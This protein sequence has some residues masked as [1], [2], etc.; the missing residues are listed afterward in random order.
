MSNR[1]GV[2]IPAR[3][4]REYLPEC[5]QSILGQSV[6]PDRVV[7]VD[8][9][10]NPPLQ[11]IAEQHGIEY[12]RI[13]LGDGSSGAAAR[14]A[15]AKTLTDCDFILPIDSDD[16]I[17]TDYIRKMLESFDG[18]HRL[19]ICYPTLYKFGQETAKVDDMYS[20]GGM[21][22]TD[23]LRQV[24]WFPVTTAWD[25]QALAQRIG[26]LGWG[27]GWSDAIYHYRVHG[28]S[29]STPWQNVARPYIETVDTSCNFIHALLV[30]TRD[31]NRKLD[32]DSLYWPRIESLIYDYSYIVIYPQHEGDGD[33]FASRINESF[34]DISS[35]WILLIDYSKPFDKDDFD[36]L[37]GSI[38]PKFDLLT[39]SDEDTLHGCLISKE[40]YKRY[41]L[42]SNEPD[43]NKAFFNQLR[44][45][46]RV[47]E[48]R[49]PCQRETELPPH[50]EQKIVKLSD[51]KVSKCQI[52]PLTPDQNQI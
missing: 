21:I 41:R 11:D 16:W 3:N 30:M 27:M 24:G 13:E 51:W 14:T 34:T 38:S 18:Q 25:E 49:K 52:S 45:D 32:Y 12:L 47:I 48:V 1:V 6:K 44:S 15:G 9:G 40:V 4:R 33:Y 29:I 22:R 35:D 39:M 26:M 28:D 37:A 20:A 43:I 42:R 50:L 23:V 31:A 8:D 2:V 17:E 46:G 5:I 19:A 36:F 10:S 7:L